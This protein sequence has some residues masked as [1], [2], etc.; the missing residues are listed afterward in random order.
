[1]EIGLPETEFGD[2]LGW[3]LKDFEYKYKIGDFKTFRDMVSI[4][5]TS[6]N[7]RTDW[8]EQYMILSFKTSDIPTWYFD[9]MHME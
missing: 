1:M 2:W 5:D 9:D 6:G 4:I 3:S 7:G 8:E